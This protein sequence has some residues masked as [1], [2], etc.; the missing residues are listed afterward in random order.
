[1]AL[2]YPKIV[3]TG[4]NGDYTDFFKTKVDRSGAVRLI[5]G[6][7]S[8]ASATTLGTIIG[9]APFT[10]GCKLLTGA[11]QIWPATYD[12]GTTVTLSVG[13]YYQDSSSAGSNIASNTSAYASSDSHTQSTS[14]P[15]L[16]V[17]GNSTVGSSGGT[18]AGL[19]SAQC[20]DL[21]GNGWFTL[22]IN[23]TLTNQA[24]TNTSF[25]LAVS[26]DQSGVTN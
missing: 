23:G 20:V 9:M 14:G 11:S 4:Y 25:S 18:T 26:Y 3:P 24:A 13:Y 17:L 15:G 16:I 10:A 8:I 5:T 22:T 12:S 7:V 19:Q 1:M 6:Q 2:V 21:Q